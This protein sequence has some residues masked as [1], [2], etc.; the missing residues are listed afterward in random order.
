M[1]RDAE[2]I[3]HNRGRGAGCHGTY[4]VAWYKCSCALP[5][6]DNAKDIMKIIFAEN[7]CVSPFFAE[8][9]CVCVRFS[10]ALNCGRCLVVRLSNAYNQQK[11]LFLGGFIAPWSMASTFGITADCIMSDSNFLLVLTAPLLEWQTSQ[12]DHVQ[13]AVS[14]GA[15][16]SHSDISNT[17][18]VKRARFS[19]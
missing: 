3:L 6:S 17:A 18:D 1:H 13:A 14:E 4:N 16:N 2:D 8:A 11:F 7:R 15:V 5:L 9:C 12:P 19:E 10:F